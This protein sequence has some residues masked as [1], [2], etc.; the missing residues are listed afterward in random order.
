MSEYTEV[1][2]DRAWEYAKTKDISHKDRMMLVAAY[3]Q[4]NNAEMLK[5]AIDNLTDN[6][7]VAI[8]HVRS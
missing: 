7:V 3:I 5:E 8:Q 4:V 6:L 1:V 2:I